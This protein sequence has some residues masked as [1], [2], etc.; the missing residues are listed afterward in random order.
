MTFKNKEQLEN[1]LLKK[2]KT[3]V[4]NTEKK[5]YKTIDGCLKKYYSEFEPKEYIR[6]KQLLHSLVKTD[7]KQVG[8]GY[9]AEV[10]FDESALDYQTG[11]VEIKST[12]ETGAMGYATW[13]AEEV[14]DTAMHGTHG[15]YISGTPIWDKSMSIL[16][17]IRQLLKQELISL[18][19][20]V[21]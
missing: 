11:W 8:K 1:F 16:G 2:C 13:G 5:V 15:G 18:G 19:V 12:Q 4:A 21:R 20:I 3:A 14:L 9:E 7:V 6:T 17:D 10:Y